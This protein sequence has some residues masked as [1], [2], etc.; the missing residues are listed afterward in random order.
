MVGGGI[1]R[2]KVLVSHSEQIKELQALTFVFKYEQNVDQVL[3]ESSNFIC[4]IFQV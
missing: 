4:R 1:Y 2:E 3:P